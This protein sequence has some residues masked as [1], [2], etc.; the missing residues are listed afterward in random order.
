MKTSMQSAAN[1]ALIGASLA[2]LC[3]WA[4]LLLAGI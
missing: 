3:V 2:V 1:A 4:A